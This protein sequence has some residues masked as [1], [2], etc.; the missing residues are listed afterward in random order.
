MS[1]PDSQSRISGAGLTVAVRSSADL[2]GQLGQVNQLLW[3]DGFYIFQ[4]GTIVISL[5]ESTLV[6]LL[7]RRNKNGMALR[8]DLVFR[9]VLPLL[10]NLLE[11]REMALEDGSVITSSDLPEMVVEQRSSRKGSMCQYVA[12]SGEFTKS[13]SASKVTRG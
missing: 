6:H 4:F 1:P 9:N 3:I 10:N 5:C 12:A 2:T 11:N 7:I 13:R 8:I